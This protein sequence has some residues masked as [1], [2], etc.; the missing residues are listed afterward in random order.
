MAHEFS[1]LGF[2]SVCLRV[3]GFAKRRFGLPYH[4]ASLGP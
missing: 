1:V 2:G 4:A 3:W